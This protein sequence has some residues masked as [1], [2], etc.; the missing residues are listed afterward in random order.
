MKIINEQQGSDTW[1]AWRSEGI[2]GSDVPA[3]FG[4]S[5]YL[6]PWALYAIKTGKAQGP[7]TN[8][9]MQKGHDY[10]PIIRS[11]VSEA[12]R[13][14]FE[15]VCGQDDPP[16]DHRRASF[17]GYTTRDGLVHLLE[18]KYVGADVFEEL[19][20]GIVRVDH[21]CQM[22]YQANVSD[23][24]SVTYGA[25]TDGVMVAHLTFSREKLEE[26]AIEHGWT[27]GAVDAFFAALKHGQG[28]CSDDFWESAQELADL[29][30]KIAADLERIEVL[31]AKLKED[32]PGS[33]SGRY[34]LT[35]RKG[36]ETL[37][38]KALSK[39]G[40][41]LAP[42]TKVGKPSIVLLSIKE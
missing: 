23:A 11:V 27:I 33:F 22:W 25:T 6:K 5:P 40:V 13:M 29:E 24:A 15:P 4:I 9:A 42:F 37:D 36:A 3:I 10:E 26:I 14:N 35:T 18:C 20:R 19:I 41:D 39:A 1:K 38:K 17:D 16:Y 28:V 30:D 21:L 31:K 2:G 8:A 34:A 7:E 32:K 12:M